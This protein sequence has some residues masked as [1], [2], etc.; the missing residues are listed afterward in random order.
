M[1]KTPVTSG[2]NTGFAA[3]TAPETFAF[4]DGGL[5]AYTSIVDPANP[6]NAMKPDAAGNVS[7]T[8]AALTSLD[9]KTPP[10]GQQVAAASSPVVL[11]AVQLAALTP[12]SNTGYAL[13]G[14]DI[15]TPTAMPAG[16]AGMRGWLS[17]IWTKLNGT[18]GV[19]GTFFQATQPVSIAATVAVSN[20]SLPLPAGAATAAKQPAPGTSGAPSSDV[21]SVQGEAGM[22][23]LRTVG[24]LALVTSSFT[25]PGDTTAY[26]AG[27]AIA[28][29]TSAPT[30]PS[31]TIARNASGT[32]YTARLI[33]QT[34][35]VTCVAPMRV[36]FYSAN[37]GQNDVDNAPLLIKDADSAIYLGYV[38]FPA[39]T[40]EAG[41]DT[42]EAYGSVSIP[43][44]ADASLKV[45][46]RPQT[47]IAFTPASGQKFTLT[48]IPDQY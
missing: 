22:T 41:S 42:T 40:T 29:S 32:G 33:L 14:A 5:G 17:A 43:F 21:I 12:P 8:N 44:V 28:T 4:A 15:S 48:A 23:P 9:G 19:T 18:I 16:G 27:D 2:A 7:V 39:F 3:G 13:D 47:R 20:A 31:I 45:Y 24:G 30:M 34:N 11:T 38:D 46:W 37:T 25:R 35:Q 1:A 10:L 6:A 36:R 26:A